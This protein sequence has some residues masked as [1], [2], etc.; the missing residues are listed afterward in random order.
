MGTSGKTKVVIRESELGPGRRG[1]EPARG[2][3]LLQAEEVRAEGGRVADGT[4][5]RASARV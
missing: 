5:E 1:R 2:A 3:S 4:K